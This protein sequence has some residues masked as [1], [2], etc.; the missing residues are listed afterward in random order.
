MSNINLRKYGIKGVKEV[1]RDESRTV[2][3][4]TRRQKKSTIFLLALFSFVPAAAKTLE[5]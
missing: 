3:C 4:E 5:A 2:H 1:L